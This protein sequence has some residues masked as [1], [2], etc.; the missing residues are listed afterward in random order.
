M[1]DITRYLTIFTI[2]NGTLKTPRDKFLFLI[3]KKLCF[4]RA[5]CFVY[6]FLIVGVDVLG[7][8]KERPNKRDVR[9]V[10]PYKIRCVV[11]FVKNLAVLFTFWGFYGII[12]LGGYLL[13]KLEFV[14][15]NDEKLIYDW[16][17]YGCWKNNCVPTA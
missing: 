16:W 5:F 9:E 15:A 10:V 2:S 13:D 1:H 4:G 8:P 14:G 6:T 11:Q 12:I 17:H 3:Y 7:D